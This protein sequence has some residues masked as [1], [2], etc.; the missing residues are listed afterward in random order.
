MI[1]RVHETKNIK[2]GGIRTQSRHRKGRYRGLIQRNFISG[3]GLAER[4]PGRGGGV[5]PREDNAIWNNRIRF[6]GSSY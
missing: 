3:V 1:Q 5:P 6:C 2:M 4:D